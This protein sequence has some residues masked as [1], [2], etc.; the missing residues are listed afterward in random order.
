MRPARGNFD[1][2]LIRRIYIGFF[3]KKLYNLYQGT[4]GVF[5]KEQKCISLVL[6]SGCKGNITTV[7]Q[8]L[9][10]TYSLVTCSKHMN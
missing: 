1:L 7:S 10:S 3:V 4:E 2:I 5:H 6:P 9:C 8:V